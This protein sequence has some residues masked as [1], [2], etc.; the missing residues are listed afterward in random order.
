[1]GNSEVQTVVA[2]QIAIDSQLN[3]EFTSMVRSNNSLVQLILKLEAA[4][5]EKDNVTRGLVQEIR[6][7]AEMRAQDLTRYQNN[8]TEMMRNMQE[9]HKNEAKRALRAVQ[10][11]IDAMKKQLQ[12]KETQIAQLM[13]ERNVIALQ[14]ARILVL[15]QEVAD[16]TALLA[17][18]NAIVEEQRKRIAELEHELEEKEK[19]WASLRQM[20]AEQQAKI[21][22]L[23]AE[24]AR[25]LAVQGKLE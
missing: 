16:L 8:L 11:A 20:L 4:S 9:V 12:D 5:A 7:S 21:Q 22:E 24:I 6:V 18:S 14:R 25:L 3:P 13:E 15:T 17:A 10:E 2:N 19:E 23:E 1:M